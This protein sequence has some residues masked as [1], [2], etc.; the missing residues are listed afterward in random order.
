MLPLRALSGAVAFVWD[1]SKTAVVV[2]LDDDH[3][4]TSE[5][6][7]PASRCPATEQ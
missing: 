3:S 6:S 7:M 2:D 1:E 4:A 5:P